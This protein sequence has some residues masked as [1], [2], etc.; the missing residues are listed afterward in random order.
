M[1]LDFWIII[2]NEDTSNSKIFM[3]LNQHRGH[4]IVQLGHLHIKAILIKIH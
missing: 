1:K 4:F 2:R 3:L